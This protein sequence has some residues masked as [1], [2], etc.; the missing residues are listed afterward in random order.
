MGSP[1]CRG[2]GVFVGE[3]ESW[4]ARDRGCPF[5]RLLCCAPCGRD[6]KET[7]QGCSGPLSGALNSPTNPIVGGP[8]TPGGVGRGRETLA[9]FWGC[10][11]GVLHPGGAQGAQCPSPRARGA[12]GGCDTHTRPL[13]PGVLPVCEGGRVGRAAAGLQT[14]GKPFLR[15]LPGSD[16]SPH[17]C[18]ACVA[19]GKLPWGCRARH[20]PRGAGGRGRGAPSPRPVPPRAVTPFSCR[21][22]SSV[23]CCFLP[24]VAG[25]SLPWL[26]APR[27]G[28]PGAFANHTRASSSDRSVWNKFTSLLSLSA[29]IP[30][31]VAC[32]HARCPPPGRGVRGVPAWPQVWEPC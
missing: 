20:P 10:W 22:R 13:G 11:F 18:R 6:R 2:W 16:E 29:Q 23:P 14:V 7:S 31:I 5:P 1:P 30:L 21:P 4:G 28:C 12:A 19:L 15:R 26:S 9:C 32:L 17:A 8:T 25:L 24:V 27:P 3:K